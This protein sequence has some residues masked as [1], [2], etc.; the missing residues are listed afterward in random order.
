[1]IKGSI[2]LYLLNPP[3]PEG[4]GV[5]WFREVLRGTHVLLTK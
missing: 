2:S 3:S 5:R 4:L 1:M